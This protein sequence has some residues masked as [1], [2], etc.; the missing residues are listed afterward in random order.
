MHTRYAAQLTQQMRDLFVFA[1]AEAE[2]YLPMVSFDEFWL[3]RDKLLPLNDSVTEVPLHL[4]IK[5]GSIWW[6]QLQQQVRGGRSR[7]RAAGAG[8]R[9][10]VCFRS[11][12]WQQLHSMGL[13]SCSG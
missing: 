4:V 8:R 1:D 9:L 5:S 12:P 7:R 13:Q 2:H 3:L 10:L 6:M 11:V